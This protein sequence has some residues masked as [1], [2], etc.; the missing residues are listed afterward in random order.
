MI[1]L[2]I[3]NIILWLIVG[4]IVLKSKKILKSV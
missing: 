2:K 1:A 3:F 4:I